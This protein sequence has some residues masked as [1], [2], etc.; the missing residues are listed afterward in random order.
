M[1]GD[2]LGVVPA[3]GGQNPGVAIWIDTRTGSPDP[4]AVS[5]DRP[6]PDPFVVGEG[7]GDE[8][9]GFPGWN[10]SPWYGDY[11]TDAWPWV[12]HS[13]HGWQWVNLES[14][15]Q[16]IFLFDLGLNEWIFLNE[17]SYRWFFLFGDTPGWV[18]SFPD[19]KPE[20]RFFVRADSGCIFSAG[21]GCP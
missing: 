13:Q 16:G 9:A 2:Y 17:N 15:S 8:I 12:Y 5:I 1:L 21:S 20:E 7:E 14:G 11:F 10:A 6:F 18:W 19:G 3:L 4:F